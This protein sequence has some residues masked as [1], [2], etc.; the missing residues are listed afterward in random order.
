MKNPWI[1]GLDVLLNARFNSFCEL[2]IKLRDKAYDDKMQK[3][4]RKTV[5]GLI[6]DACNRARRDMIDMYMDISCYTEYDDVLHN[7]YVDKG[8]PMV[9]EQQG[10]LE[11]AKKL[12]N[13]QLR[14]FEENLKEETE[15][16]SESKEA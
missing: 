13:Q 6:L 2:G 9:E 4:D 10:R 15:S 16:C 11:D 12:F 7:D 3:W 8:W 1:D 14:L 5:V